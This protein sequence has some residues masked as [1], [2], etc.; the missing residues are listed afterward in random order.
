MADKIK[1]IP[2]IPIVDYF[3]N[4]E[5]PLNLALWFLCRLA[6][7]LVISLFLKITFIQSMKHITH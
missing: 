1:Q 6:F 7:A 2:R 5:R 4:M 3:L